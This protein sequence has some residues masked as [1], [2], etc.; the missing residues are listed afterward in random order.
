MPKIEIEVRL[1]D[2][3][4]ALLAGVTTA[5]KAVTGGKPGKPAKPAAPEPADDDDDFDNTDGDGDGAGDGEDDGAGDDGDGDPE[6][7]RDD[8]QAALRA[9][10]DVSSKAAAIKLMSKHGESDALSKVKPAKYAAV[11]DAAK[12][13]TK[14][15]A[16][17]K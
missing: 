14:A 17:K 6:P 5:A 8:V 11:I 9:Y 16:A 1:S 3:D 4:R 7:T 10:A 2:E 13:A 12:K 15:K